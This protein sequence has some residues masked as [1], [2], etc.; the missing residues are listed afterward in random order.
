MR[1]YQ[2]TIII[3]ILI[4]C[5]SLYFLV[6]IP[7]NKL[8][9]LK[10]ISDN[11]G[12]FYPNE[13]SGAALKGQQI[14]RSLGCYYCHTKIVKPYEFGS[15][16]E[17]GWG[18]R[19]LVAR[20]FL[21]DSLILPGSVRLAPDLS[22]IGLRKPEKFSVP[23]KYSS[24]NQ[25]I[26]IKEFDNRLFVLLYDPKLINP[27]SIMPS[28]KYMFKTHQSNAIGTLINSSKNFMTDPILINDTMVVPTESAIY[29]VEYLKSLKSEYPL[30]EAPPPLDPS[31]L[32][33]RASGITNILQSTSP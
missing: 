21:A 31:R 10:Q 15:D 26:Q 12:G 13:R 33:R 29:L 16:Y 9:A 17:R 28:F 3:T 18:N 14:Y 4:L 8:A 7:L 23:W 11:A 27:Q 20:D 30:F 6:L 5:A 25:T 32:V 19:R 2:T 24:T 22:N 1:Y